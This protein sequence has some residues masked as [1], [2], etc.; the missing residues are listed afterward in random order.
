MIAYILYIYKLAL[1]ASFTFNPLPDRLIYV[2]KSPHG[3][4]SMP[5]EN[6]AG[7]PPFTLRIDGG[8]QANRQVPQ[9]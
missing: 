3:L 2:A 7:N 4:T 5:R 9:Y 8:S 1:V 6:T